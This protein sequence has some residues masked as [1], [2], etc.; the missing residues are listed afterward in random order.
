MTASSG[1]A[2][3]KAAGTRVLIVEDDP[4]QARLL[5][6]SLTRQRPDLT[7]ITSGNGVEAARLVSESAV[8]L[9]LTEL[10]MPGM[11]GF[12]FLTCCFP[13]PVVK[14]FARSQ[15]PACDSPSSCSRYPSATCWL[16]GSN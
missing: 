10:T 12:E 3:P 16:R 4:A 14:S 8:A 5:S 7:V 15:P 6:R 2:T 13:V 1:T 9:I 11:D